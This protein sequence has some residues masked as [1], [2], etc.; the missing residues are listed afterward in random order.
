MAN[1]QQH[2][3]P[4]DGTL[5]QRKD[6]TWEYR[7]IITL[8]DGTQ[9][10][11]SFYS[12]DKTGTGAKKKYRDWISSKEDPLSAVYTV[13]QWASLWLQTYKKDKVAPKSYKN[14]ELYI[15]KHIIPTL[16]EYALTEVKP[17]HI[18][19]FFSL[20]SDLSYSA[21][22][23]LYIILNSLFETAT[24][25]NY[26]RNNPCKRI[27][28]HDD[29]SKTPLVFS[30]QEIEAIL[31]YAPQHPYGYYVTAFLYTGLRIGELT[32]LQ[33][34]NVDLDNGILTIDQAL[35][36]TSESGKKYAI[37]PTT[38][39][40]K[41][42]QVV[43]SPEGINVFKS[44]PRTGL[45]VIS[46]K[47][48][49][50]VNPDVY[51]KHYD[52]F[53]ADLNVELKKEHQKSSADDEPFQVRPLSPHKCRHTHATY[54]LESGANIRAVQEQLGHAHISTTEIYTHVDINSLKENVSKLSF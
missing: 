6:G 30:K 2:N 48:G 41:A 8:P 42:R 23:H 47:N 35:A 28:V 3:S 46:N 32:A 21:R 53:F 43:L 10:R 7:A 16:G 51:R 40:K 33:W 34:G 15:N 22:H 50:F 29:E 38:K 52:K 18:E 25:N 24:D 20:E 11:K 12:K 19:T 27:V 26:C 14:Y 1:K 9:S 36:A 37:K 13:G 45:F 31:A 44:I 39:T 4:G 49:A 5:R 54:L 17:V